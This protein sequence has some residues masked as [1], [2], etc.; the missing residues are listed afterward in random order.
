MWSQPQVVWVNE[1]NFVPGAAFAMLYTFDPN[2]DNPSA[3]PEWTAVSYS[4]LTNTNFRN[5]TDLFNISSDGGVQVNSVVSWDPLLDF[6]WYQRVKVRGLFNIVA[7]ACDAGIPRRCSNSTVTVAVQSAN[8]SA[9]LPII[10][11]ISVPLQGLSS[12]G[13]E[14]IILTGSDFPIGG[15]LFLDYRS[16]TGNYGFTATGCAIRSDS[17]AECLTVRRRALRWDH[18]VCYCSA[19]MYRRHA[20]VHL[21]STCRLLDTAATCSCAW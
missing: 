13:G 20:C 4:L 7:Q 3:P 15:A 16:E 6:G 2:T 9:L 10:D 18:G 14:Q 19:T 11:T 5:N 17:I 1:L 8:S 12:L 21:V